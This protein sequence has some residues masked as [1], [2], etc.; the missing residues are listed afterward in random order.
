[1]QRPRNLVPQEVPEAFATMLKKML[2]D[3]DQRL[4]A[5][6]ATARARGWR[7]ATLAGVL[8]MKDTACSKR[9]ERADPLPHDVVARQALRSASQKLTAVARHAEAARLLSYSEQADPIERLAGGSEE[10]QRAAEALE[11]KKPWQ[12]GPPK[13]FLRKIASARRDLTKAAAYETKSRPDVSDI[14]IPE[15]RRVQA[16]MNGQRLPLQDVERLKQMQAVA[17]RVNGAMAADHPDRVVSER[18]TA[19]LND[20][21][22]QKGFTPYYLAKELGVTHRAITSRLERHGYREPCPSVVG[23][24]SGVYRGRKIGDAEKAE[25]GSVPVP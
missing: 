20:L 23:T 9:I 7:T 13:S 4:N 21:I 6:L 12:T 14:V 10:V 15:P 3:H 24:P 19:E 11:P 18:Y 5:V 22:T 16:M 8:G 25:P 2:T 17:S 1:M